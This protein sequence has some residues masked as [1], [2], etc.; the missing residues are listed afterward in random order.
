MRLRGAGLSCR[1]GLGAGVVP[2]LSSWV[3]MTCRL[4]E[5]A[6]T[7]RRG[8]DGYGGQEDDG[9]QGGA[10]EEDGNRGQDGSGQEDHRP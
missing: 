8:Q 6:R 4:A 9:D 10:G 5:S 3:V 2:A 1:V 7:N